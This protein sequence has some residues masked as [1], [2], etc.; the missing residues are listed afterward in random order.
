MLKK[1][2]KNKHFKMVRY[3]TTYLCFYILTQDK[4]QERNIQQ[5]HFSQ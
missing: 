1:A 2:L 3:I 5:G 4:S